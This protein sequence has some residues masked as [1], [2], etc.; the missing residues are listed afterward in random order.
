MQVKAEK[1]EIENVIG[2]EQTTK[3]NSVTI[4][5]V[6]VGKLLICN[7]AEPSF[8]LYRVIFHMPERADAF[9]FWMTVNASVNAVVCGILNQTYR[10]TLFK[11]LVCRIPKPMKSLEN[12]RIKLETLQ[13][14]LK[15]QKSL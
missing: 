10:K 5:D 15:T 12:P 6:I 14:K 4:M 11:L 9:F 3:H 13:K 1:K 7:L 8:F 2:P